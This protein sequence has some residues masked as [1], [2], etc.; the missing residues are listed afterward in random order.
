MKETSLFEDFEKTGYEAWRAAAEETLAGAP[1]EKKLCT[2]TPEG[3]LLQPIYNAA[4]AEKCGAGAELPGW[5]NFARGATAAPYLAEGWQIA[6]EIFAT[7]PSEWN[8][9]ALEALNHGQTAL[10]MAAGGFKAEANFD[11]AFRDIVLSAVPL[12]WKCLPVAEAQD[13]IGRLAAYAARVGVDA[14]TLK[15]GFELDA[16][17]EELRGGT[18]CSFAELAEIF[19]ANT[20]PQMAV[21]GIS[22]VGIAD[23][24]GTAVQELSY[25]LGATVEMLRQLE[26][27]GVPPQTVLAR[28]RWCFSVGQNY[29]IEVAKFRAARVLWANLLEAYGLKNIPPR[30][31]ARTGRM[32]KT[33]YDP[34]VNIL[35][36]SMEAFAAVVG[37]VESLSVEPFDRLFRTPEVLSQRLARN[38][39]VILREEC[40]L[41]KIVDPAGGAYFIETLTTQL[42]EA[43]WKLF[44]E[45]EKQGGILAQVR[46]GALQKEIAAA[47]AERA[48]RF[49]QRRDVLVGTNLYAVVDEK[50]I[51]EVSLAKAGAAVFRLSAPYEELR[52]SAATVKPKVFLCTMGPLR[53]HKARADFV[54]AFLEAGGINVIYPK[55]FETSAE[56]ARAAAESG[57]KVAVICSTDELYPALVPEA[58]KALKTASPQMQ[59]YLAGQPAAEY[60]PAY[61]AAGMDDFISIR[62]NHLETL[63]KII[64]LYA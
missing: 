42:G 46:S 51:G 22:A 30:L 12:Y 37:G 28:T 10:L 62:S 32:N 5:G 21:M 43:S 14:A 3:I 15:G 60:E 40:E 25:A 45:G 26:A 36:A 63:K 2:Q 1:F 27:E 31:H 47:A 41:D 58:A 7:S 44:Q 54:Q 50:P 33:L 16:V 53:E 18:A 11:A 8:K 49:G 19:K 59:V 56:A 35:R 23:A 38:A 57:A 39:Q 64:T 55:G 6:Q 34:H 17:A 61:R 4:D 24:G 13:F 9:L 48:K 20:F 52:A 29:F